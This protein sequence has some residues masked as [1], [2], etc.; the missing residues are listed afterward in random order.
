MNFLGGTSTTGGT[1]TLTITSGGG[2]A[3]PAYALE[4]DE[5]TD[6]LIVEYSDSTR[7]TVVQAEAG[8]GSVSSSN[9]LTR[10]AV[11]NSWVASGPTYDQDASVSA[12]NFGTSNVWVYIGPNALQT[13]GAMVQRG[14]IT[15]AY[16]S[17]PDDW[18][19]ATNYTDSGDFTT[20]TLVT[21]ATIC[22]PMKIEMGFTLATMGVK[23]TTAQAAKSVSIALATV[24]ATNGVPGRVIACVNDLSLAST[25]IVSG[26]CT[27]RKIRPGWYYGLFLSDASTAVI[28]GSALPLPNFF[29][30]LATN[31]RT[32]RYFYRTRTF[33]SSAFSVG[34]DGMASTSGSPTGIAN[35]AAPLI[36]MR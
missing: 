11:V 4:D 31:E 8:Y 10:T 34:G 23:V 36:L 25:G 5:E 1:S 9:V 15:T 27:A 16:G 29:G 3:L 13:M 7:A 24:T 26:S 20:H 12:L 14:K 18:I 32:Q 2:L 35:L 6:Y 17:G 33:G 22:V 21:N 30:A 19:I 28:R